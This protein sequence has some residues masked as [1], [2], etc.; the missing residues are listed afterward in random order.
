MKRQFDVGVIWCPNPSSRRV[1]ATGG[2]RR[3]G[4]V[5]P[6]AVEKQLIRDCEGKRVLQLFGGQ[7]RFGLRVDIDPKTAPAVIA[8]AWLPP[9]RQDSFDVVI[10]D[11]PY[12]HLNGQ[13][14]TAL[15]RAAGFI[16][17]E[18]VIWFSTVWMAASGGLSTEAA[19]LVRVGDSCAARVLQYFKVT[20]K[21]GPVKRFARGPAMKYNR[22]LAQP[23]SLPLIAAAEAAS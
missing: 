8:D 15:F 11:P 18:R 14:K 2:A 19:W 23:Q 3:T 21:F 12:I 6:P 17:K 10:L 13:M 5:F 22:W 4:W 9:F 16:A 7:S 20:R 1:V